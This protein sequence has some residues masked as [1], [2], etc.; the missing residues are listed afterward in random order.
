MRLA[1]RIRA[2]LF[3]RGLKRAV[4][5]AGHDRHALLLYTVAAFDSDVDP[6]RHQNIPQQREIAAALGERG[7]E[8]DVADY[9]E[10]RAGLLPHAYDLVIDLHP[11]RDPV[12]ARHLAAGAV[13]I[14]YIT[15]SD[16]AFANRAERERSAA[17]QRR[18][19]VQ[20]KAR[21]QT[22]PFEPDVL[23]A[24][25][26]MF[27]I[28]G[29]ATRETYAAYPL[30]AVHTLP[31]SAFDAIV[32]TD[33]ATRDPKRFLFLASAGQVHKG[34]DLLLDVF[35]ERPHL[36][37]E[38]VSG[39]RAEPDFARAFHRELF[40]TPNIRARGMLPVTGEAFRDLQARCGA[41]L[42]PSC[43][44]GQCGTVTIALAWGLPCI[45]SRACGFDDPEIATLP[46]CEPATIGAAV[47]RAAARPP[48]AVAAASAAARRTYETRYR[49]AHYAAALRAALDDVLK[50]KAEA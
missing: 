4:A 31:N 40:E 32:A 34:L 14:A 36:T 2:K 10:T 38:V 35:R 5:G 8:V 41:M 7:Y 18:R 28:G 44:E 39:F 25:D 50:A 30:R 43:A 29:S 12:Y 22:P 26:A 48:D 9:D 3:G 47:E 6:T 27:L 16:P 37:L 19:G 46:D 11:R 24:Y 15:G 33:P 42:M 45:V 1:A 17:L 13:R 21:R 20:L 23:G 49:P